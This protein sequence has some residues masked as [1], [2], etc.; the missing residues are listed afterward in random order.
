[1]DT[2]TRATLIAAAAQFVAAKGDSRPFN[3]QVREKSMELAALASGGSDLGHQI[4]RLLDAKVFYATILGVEREERSTR[5]LVT[6]K[7]R[8]SK[9]HPDGIE[10][11]R[12]DRTD[13]ASGLAMAKKVQSLKGHRVRVWVAMEPAGDDIDVR[14]LAWIEDLGVDKHLV[15]QTA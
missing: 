14:V 3:E 2:N 12:T 6:M 1:M 7:T 8:P 13:N 5:G 10:K 11:V 15:E 4:D 9:F